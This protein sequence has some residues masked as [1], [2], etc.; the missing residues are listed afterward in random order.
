MGALFLKVLEMSFM[1]SVVI[2]ITIL[3]RFFLR[4]RSK[5]FIMILWA[6]VALRL[7]VP[8][9]IESSFSIFNYLPVPAQTMPATAEVTEAAMPDNTDAPQAS[10]NAAEITYA[11]THIVN[12]AEITSPQKAV[13]KTLPDIRTIIAV[14]WLTGTLGII[15]YCS[16]RYISLKRKL[17]NAK[18]IEKNIYVSDTVKS[19]FVFGFFVPKMYLPDTLDDIER[20]CVLAHERTHIKHGD[21]IKKLLG[22]AVLAVHWFN[23]LVWLAFVLFEQDIEMSCDETA[24][25]TLDADLRKAYA[26]SLVSYAKISNNKKY[27]VTPLGFSK[28]AFGK[29]EVTNR[30]MNIV[31]YKKASRIT[32]IIITA[33]M[34]VLA[35]ACSFNS[36][37]AASEST[38]DTMASESATATSANES[39]DS[40]VSETD[41]SRIAVNSVINSIHTFENGKCKDCGMHWT[42][43]YY[44]TLEKLD[45]DSKPGEWHSIYG[46][47]SDAMFD[48]GDYVQF[49]AYDDITSVAYFQH[50]NEKLDCESCKIGVSNLKEKTDTV[51]E[52]QF[53]QGYHS[54]G[55]GTMNYKFLYRLKIRVAPGEFDKVFESKEAFASSCDLILGV[56]VERDS[57]N[58]MW[59]SMS[60]EQIKAM[61][62]QEGCT[63]YSK[64]QIIDMFWNDYSRMLA[65]IDNGMSVMD[66][67]LADAGIN[68][69]K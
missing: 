42:E 63:Y 29:A 50:M 65:S 48:E 7:I 57:Y 54:W 60:E 9:G 24:I 49:W 21:W 26:I 23:P 10:Y 34:L 18:R 6:A 52:F 22:M 20:E 4:K 27:L 46:P 8:F 11:G 40:S 64:E 5:G 66:T 33:S 31:N 19:P 35:A 43:Y 13:A 62:E 2:V 39:V 47:Q 17:R 68:W 67:S 14:V 61:F 16:V 32:S 37:P 69:K 3:A 56:L 41:V 30:V 36:K 15:A 44:Q 28:N 38:T 53:E 1:G 25:A 12:D 45:K 58:E 51:I 59:T 55:D